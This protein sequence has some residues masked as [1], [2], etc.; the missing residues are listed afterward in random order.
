ME[1]KPK[2]KPDIEDLLSSI[3][4]IL[5][6]IQKHKGPIKLTPDL[7]SDIDKLEGMVKDFKEC[8]EELFDMCDIDIESLKKEVIES[9]NIRSGDKQ[10]IKRSEDIERD[11]RVFKL[12][13]SKA[14]SKGRGKTSKGKENDKRKIKERRKLFKQIGGDKTWLPL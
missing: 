7:I 1:D 8:S 2:P 6:A 10:L 11:A 9:P 3:N 5:D 12:A 13:L 4:E 14:K